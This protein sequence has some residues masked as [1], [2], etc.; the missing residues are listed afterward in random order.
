M[1][2]KGSLTLDRLGIQFTKRWSSDA[3]RRLLVAFD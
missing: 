3:I 1:E 2:Y